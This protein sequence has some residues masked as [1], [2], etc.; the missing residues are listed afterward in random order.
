MMQPEFESSRH[1]SVAE[2]AGGKIANMESARF[3][4]TV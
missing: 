2:P 1:P 3:K 4:Q